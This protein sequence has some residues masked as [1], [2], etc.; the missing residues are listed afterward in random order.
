MTS[1]C[2]ASVCINT[3]FTNP[4]E[5]EVCLASIEHEPPV[6]SRP[7]RA[8]K[9]TKRLIMSMNKDAEYYEEEFTKTVEQHEAEIKE[10][11]GSDDDDSSTISSVD[12]I[13]EECDNNSVTDNFVVG[14]LSFPDD[15]YDPNVITQEDHDSENDYDENTDDENDDNTVGS[16][17]SDDEEVI[18][19]VVT[20]PYKDDLLHTG[21]VEDELN[22]IS[23]DEIHEL[24]D[25]ACEIQAISP[26]GLS[27]PALISGVFTCPPE[28][29]LDEPETVGVL[30]TDHRTLAFDEVGRVE[31]E[32]T[33]TSMMDVP[34]AE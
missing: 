4:I 2:D 33:K 26:I 11:L 30:E 10:L 16:F 9:R 1:I 13:E 14:S 31:P 21:D 7:Q 18:S 25:E 23:D 3:T 27:N 34:C 17:N 5:S 22:H 29:C 15:E 12:E 20:K 6:F 28:I 19:G 24:V 32:A 8:R